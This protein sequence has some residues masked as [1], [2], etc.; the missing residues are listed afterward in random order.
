M[1]NPFGN[2]ADAPSITVRA[3]RRTKVLLL[4]ACVLFGTVAAHTVSP[5]AGADSVI[6]SYI[7]AEERRDYMQIYRLFSESRTQRLRREKLADDAASY[8]RLRSSSEARWS[9]FVEIERRRLKGRMLVTFEV[10]IE[11]VGERE[12][13]R[14]T[15][16]LLLQQDQWRI[17]AIDY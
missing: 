14:V 2:A 17:D 16:T 10:A 7:S 15:I 9:D 3:L 1:R 4:L 8:A 6:R 13:Q 5:V 12:R 11:E